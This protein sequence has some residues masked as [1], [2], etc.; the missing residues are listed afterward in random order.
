LPCFALLSRDWDLVYL[1]PNQVQY[2]RVLHCIYLQ[3]RAPE[4]WRRIRL[5]RRSERA[6][7]CVADDLLTYQPKGMNPELLLQPFLEN[8]DL[9][10]EYG[11][12]LEQSGSM[13]AFLGYA[14]RSTGLAESI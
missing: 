1:E 9:L 7:V 6:Q 13:W 4:T 8:T 10:R 14:L 11:H 3:N 2:R 5:E 12:C